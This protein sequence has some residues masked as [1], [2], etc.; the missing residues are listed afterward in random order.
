MKEQTW[1]FGGVKDGIDPGQY[2]L[3]IIAVRDGKPSQNDDPSL[4]IQFRVTEGEFEGENAFHTLWFVPKREGRGGSLP[5][6][7][8]FLA[9]AG[10]DPDGTYTFS[11]LK[12]DLEGKLLVGNAVTEES[13]EYGPRTVFK[14]FSKVRV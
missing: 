5:F 9:A 4:N 10:L 7:K 14:S 11:D 8:R 12:V 2:V 3:E 1:D 13:E 6:V